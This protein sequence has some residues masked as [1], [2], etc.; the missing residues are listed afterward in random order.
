M[1]L[2]NLT[3]SPY[4]IALSNGDVAMLPARGRLD[5]VEPSESCVA[6]LR[7]CGYIKTEDSDAKPS[8]DEK[9][10]DK[11]KRNKKRRS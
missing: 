4:N 3:N 11:P 1:N 5:D 7:V 2:I 8:G 9:E 10:D 6:Q